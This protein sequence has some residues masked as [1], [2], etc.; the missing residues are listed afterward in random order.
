MEQTERAARLVKLMREEEWQ[1]LLAI[2]RLSFSLGPISIQRISQKSGL[3]KEKVRFALSSLGLKKAV[4]RKGNS[5]ILNTLA[6]EMLALHYYAKRNL[7]DALGAIVAKGKESDVYEAF[8]QGGKLLAIKFYKIG[9]TSFRSVKRKRSV[10]RK[11]LINWISINYNA[12]RK[13]FESLKRLEGSTYFPRV[14]AYN[15]NTVLME[16]LLGLRL[17]TRPELVDKKSIFFEILSAVRE[18][19]KRGIVNSD[20]S[21]YN[22]LTDGKKVW[23]IDWPQSI[24]KTNQNFKVS[25]KKDLERVTKFFN[26]T[27]NLGEDLERALNFVMS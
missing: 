1:V 14:F 25:L 20:L 10:T 11:A 6:I 21:E 23:I 3:D 7:V 5:F 22:I 27:Y 12:A 15:R 8:G 18:A 4:M 17:S 26:K 13:E 16:H 9:R 19:Y 2:E 24:D